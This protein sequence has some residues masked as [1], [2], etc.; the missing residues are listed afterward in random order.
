MSKKRFLITALVLIVLSA[1]VYL[2]V[3]TWKKFDWHRFWAA[4]H[5]THKL[6]LAAG[7]ALVY[8]DYVLRAVRW[9]ILLRPVC[10]ARSADLVAPTMIGFTGLALLGRPGEFIRP[11]L[12]SRKLNLSMSSQ[13]A[14]WTVERIFDTGAF[15]VI[16]AVN[17]LAF[18]P[19][20]QREVP[21]FKERLTQSFLGHQVL[22][23]TLFEIV[24]V[25][26]LVGVAGAALLAFKVRQNPSAAARVFVRM[27]GLISPK[28]G[29][30]VGKRV[31]A[32]GEGL[33]TVKD[34]TSF[35]Q[36]SGISLLVWL[37]IGFA[38][39]TVTHAYAIHRLSRMTLSS[40][41]LLTAASVVGGVLQLPVVGGGSQLAT[42]GMLRGVFDLSPELATSCG[43]MLW[44]VTFMSVSPAGLALA[45]SEHVSLTRIEEESLEEEQKALDKEMDQT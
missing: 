17:I 30:A 43:I 32:F 12:I 35:L 16:M 7:V 40:V 15:A 24:A 19:K 42:I 36:L 23:F 31:H 34:L 20:L 25:A 45:H 5:N 28:V 29:H 6:Y 18:A 21:A 2:Q 4:T 22:L 44:L 3:R 26:L 27:F 14:V 11:Y 33:N 10:E 8:F 38:Y 41:F 1:L 37:V 13:V 39:M 9:K